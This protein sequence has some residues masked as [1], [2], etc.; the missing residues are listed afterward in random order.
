MD[1]LLLID[2]QFVGSSVFPL[3]PSPTTLH[4][5]KDRQSKLSKKEAVSKYEFI[6]P[7]EYIVHRSMTTIYSDRYNMNHS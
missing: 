2:E 6:P 1:V 5:Q 3:Y 7:T 4:P